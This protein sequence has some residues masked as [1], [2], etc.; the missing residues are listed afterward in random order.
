MKSNMVIDQMMAR[1]SIRK[2]T[3][4]V[5]SN[6]V[7]EAIVRAGQQAPF[8]AQLGS[9]LLSRER[10]RHPFAAPLN[11]V[12]CVDAHRLELVMARREWKMVSND[13][14]LLIFGIQDACY[15]AENMVSAAESLGLGSCF[16][17]RTP[18]RAST[19]I[20]RF[21]LPPRIFPLVELVMGYPAEDPP[22][23]PRYPLAA[24]LHDGTYRQFTEE[25]LDEAMRVMD[26]GYLAQEYYKGIGY[27]VPL[28]GDREETF[29]FD[30]YSWTEHM[31]RKWGQWLGSPEELLNE[32]AV[33]GFRVGP[34]DA[35]D[36]GD[37]GFGGSSHD[38]DAD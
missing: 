29:T 36:D 31:G 17:G 25:D 37:V 7:I 13:L 28:E 30:D 26:E 18:Y 21:K 15:M 16:I 35:G 19:V 20:E 27:M 5:P 22:P 38:P 3:D 12:I 1:K 23:R 6:E 10:N 2:F 33:C 14:S 24:H 34:A 32:M 11:F 4:D 9:V 8:A